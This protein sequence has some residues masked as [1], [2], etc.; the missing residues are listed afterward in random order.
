VVV[1][2]VVLVVT[3]VV[4]FLSCV[5]VCDLFLSCLSV[6]TDSNLPVHTYPIHRGE[7]AAP[8][9]VHQFGRAT[10]LW[11]A[12]SAMGPSGSALYKVRVKKIVA[13]LRVRFTRTLPS[14]LPYG[15]A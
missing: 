9:W 4:L 6:H 1:C 5:C 2:G 15:V 10:S 14:S 13:C 7:W 12:C 11:S 8:T 3:C